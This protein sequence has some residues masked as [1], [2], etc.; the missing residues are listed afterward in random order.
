MKDISK[1][2]LEELERLKEKVEERIEA[3][4]PEE[5]EVH[6]DPIITTNRK[7]KQI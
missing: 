3:L 7:L 5:T 4:T 1:M 6:G 2:K